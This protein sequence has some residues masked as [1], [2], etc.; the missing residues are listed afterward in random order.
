M[1]HKIRFCGKQAFHFA[2]NSKRSST[3]ATIWVE[4]LLDLLSFNRFEV[5]PRLEL[6]ARVRLQYMCD[7]QP[8]SHMNRHW[9]D[10]KL[11]F[12]GQF[13]N[14]LVSIRHEISNKDIWATTPSCQE[15]EQSNHPTPVRVANVNCFQILAESD[16][17][18]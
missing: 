15:S 3:N 8:H 14:R 9:N 6:Y 11:Y 2:F 13:S 7:V 4:L 1:G 5:M 16:M 10:W 17:K 12:S 18:I